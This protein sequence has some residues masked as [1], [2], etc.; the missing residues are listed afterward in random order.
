MEELRVFVINT[1]PVISQA[2]RTVT[3]ETAIDS[4]AML[5]ELV[6]GVA[7]PSSPRTSMRG[8]SAAAISRAEMS[9]GATKIHFP[10]ECALGTADANQHHQ[11]NRPS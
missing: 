4:L 10:T 2:D 9:G 11:S 6:A 3:A 5:Q 7:T 8:I 1:N